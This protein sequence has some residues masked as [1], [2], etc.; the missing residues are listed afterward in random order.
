MFTRPKTVLIGKDIAYTGAA[1]D[2]KLYVHGGSTGYSESAIAGEITIFDE[3]FRVV[4]DSVYGVEAGVKSIYIGQVLS[5]TYTFNDHAGVAVTGAHRIKFSNRIDGALIKRVVGNPYTAKAEQATVITT[6]LATTVGLTHVLRIVYRDLQDQKGGGQ[7]VHSYRYTNVTND[8]TTTINHAITA[9][10]NKHA[11]ARVVATHDNA[12]SITLTGKPIP[13]CTTGVNDI[14]KFV[15]VEF[16]VTINYVDAD[17]LFA[18]TASTIATTAA[19]YGSGNWEQVRDAERE[20][21]G[22]KGITSQVHWPVIQPD[23]TV[24]KTK[25]YDQIVIEHDQEYL[26][27]D[28][29]YMKRAPLTTIL[30]FVTDS[31]QL[32]TFI[33]RL[34]L[35]LAGT[36]G[37]PKL[38]SPVAT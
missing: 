7:F 26:S 1:E 4:A 11:G 18:E 23:L 28:N 22:N 10:V 3:A 32:T 27:S 2:L 33:T 34:N 16:D 15:M 13:S 17:G 20:A 30:Y 12:T 24:D 19:I 5:D 14:D 29:Q 38:I 35:W 36:P 21:L 6:T 8:T 31:S 37:S 25:T 9:L